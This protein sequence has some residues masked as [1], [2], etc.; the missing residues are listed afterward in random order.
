MAAFPALNPSSRAYT[1][2]SFPVARFTS[3]SGAQNRVLLGASAV[4]A[5]L[6]LSFAFF[7]EAEAKQI[8]DHYAGEKGGYTGFA[9]SANLSAD[10][11][12]ITLTPSGNTWIYDEAPSVEYVAD[13]V[14]NVTV[15][16]VS[17]I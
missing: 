8:L 10:L 11:A 2:G 12:T 1:P 15:S 13:N 7:T 6:E 9:L 4:A 16:L 14:Y 3:A 17:V 5:F